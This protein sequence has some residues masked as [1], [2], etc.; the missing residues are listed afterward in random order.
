VHA[1]AAADQSQHARQHKAMI[2]MTSK[3]EAKGKSLI[4][5]CSPDPNPTPIDIKLGKINYVAGF[6]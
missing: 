1:A 5:D 3:S 2:R 6:Y 4:F